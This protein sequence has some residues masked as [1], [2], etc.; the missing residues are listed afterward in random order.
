MV[1]DGQQEVFY[2]VSGRGTLEVGG[3]K[4]GYK[5]RWIAAGCFE[6]MAHD[7]RIPI[8]RLVDGSGGGPDAS[9][10]VF[11]HVAIE[12]E[13]SLFDQLHNGCGSE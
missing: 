1:P 10:E 7:L 8:V 9:F 11:V 3:E 4:Y 12:I 6:A 2:V 13:L 5:L